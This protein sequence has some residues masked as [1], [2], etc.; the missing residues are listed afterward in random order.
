MIA[1][2]CIH[3]IYDIISTFSTTC[4]ALSYDLDVTSVS[5]KPSPSEPM[6]STTP[7]LDRYLNRGAANVIRAGGSSMMTQYRLGASCRVVHRRSNL[8][9]VVV[10]VPGMTPPC[11]R[12]FFSATRLL[13]SLGSTGSFEILDRMTTLPCVF[14]VPCW[15][16]IKLDRK[17]QVR[18]H[19]L[20]DGQT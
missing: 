6:L 16:L 4:A 11:R 1:L 2:P 20:C 15:M 12:P 14:P 5:N 10:R 19:H 18:L 7:R 13:E 8:G 17:L 9:C 3:N